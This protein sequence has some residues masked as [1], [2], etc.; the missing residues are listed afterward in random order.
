RPRPPPTPF[1]YTT[2]FRSRRLCEA[3]E[4]YFDAAR[5]NVARRHGAKHVAEQHVAARDRDLRDGDAVAHAHDAKSP[6]LLRVDAERAA[7]RSEEHT[8]EL[9]SQSK[10][11]M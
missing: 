8:S 3:V 7:L 11:R 9:Q 2:L 1:P 10:S 4:I 5:R 6:D